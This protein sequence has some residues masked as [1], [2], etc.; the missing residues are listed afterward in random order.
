MPQT[1]MATIL[2]CALNHNAILDQK[3]SVRQAGRIEDKEII[4]KIVQNRWFIAGAAFILGALVILGIRFVTYQPPK[5]VHYHA[6]FAVYVNGEQEK[7]KSPKYYT[8]VEMC[9]EAT[10]PIDPRERAHMHDNVYDVVHVEDNAVTWGQFFQN[11]GIVV[12]AN[13]VRIGDK[14]Y[15]SDDQHKLT[16]MLNG[17]KADSVTQKI[18]KDGD[19]LLVS[20]GS[21]S[22]EELK[23]QFASVASTAHTYDTTPDPASCSGDKKGSTMQD[24]LMHMF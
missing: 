20:Y 23:Q 18:I 10:A 24:R 9:T 19:R 2:E 8:D 13:V 21:G 6:N 4:V 16:F 1:G 12:D 14:L 7:F 17:E 15:T 11:L 3:A 22:Q 5:E